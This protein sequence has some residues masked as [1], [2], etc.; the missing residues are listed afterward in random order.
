MSRTHSSSLLHTWPGHCPLQHLPKATTALYNICFICLTQN[1]S[2]AVVSAPPARCL[3]H[4][5]SHPTLQHLSQHAACTNL[6]PTLLSL[7]TTALYNPC[8]SGLCTHQRSSLGYSPTPTESSLRDRTIQIFT[9]QRS[10]LGYSPTPT[11]SSLR[12]RTIQIFTHQ[13]SALSYSPMP[14]ESS[15]G[16]RT[17]QISGLAPTNA[18]LSATRLRPQSHRLI[19]LTV[20]NHPTGSQSRLA[21][22]NA[23]LSWWIDQGMSVGT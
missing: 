12:D 15:L 1:P 21:P 9:H 16:D 3:Q 13:R 17:I 7:P 14:T 23:L 10:S 11:E 22:T 2:T 5:A 18:P 20:P 6:P 19:V 8:P 4:S